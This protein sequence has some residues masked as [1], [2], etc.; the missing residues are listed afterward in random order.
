MFIYLCNT[1]TIRACHL[2]KV[3]SSPLIRRKI[4]KTSFEKEET[5]PEDQFFPICLGQTLVHTG[6]LITVSSSDVFLNM[7][8]GEYV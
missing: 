5:N 2:Y 1:N 4:G 6:T 3:T 8:I 7:G